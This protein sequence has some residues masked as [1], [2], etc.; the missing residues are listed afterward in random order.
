MIAAILFYVFDPNE[1]AIFPQCPFLLITGYKCPGCG[2]QRAIH[3]FM[4]LQI[5][6]ALKY[7]AF[8]VFAVP[9]ILLGVYVEHLGGKKRHP[10]L[11]KALFN[12]YSAIVVLIGILLYWI[13][14][15]L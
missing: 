5:W 9:Y 1:I 7:N 4:H 12:K 10:K 2:T 13:M 11:E 6:E 8:I 3:S 15:N 14:R